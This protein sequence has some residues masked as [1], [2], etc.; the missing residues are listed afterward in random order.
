VLLVFL[1]E[2]RDR[3]EEGYTPVAVGDGSF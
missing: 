2:A 1:P 3:G